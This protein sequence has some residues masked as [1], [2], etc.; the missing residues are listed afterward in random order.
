ME[1]KKLDV[2]RD[3]T[4]KALRVIH[5]NFGK[6]I[7]HEIVNGKVTR[8]DNDGPRP[9]AEEYSIIKKQA[10]GILRGSKKNKKVPVRRKKSRQFLADE[11][12]AYKTHAAIEDYKLRHKNVSRTEA[13]KEVLRLEEQTEIAAGLHKWR[14]HFLASGIKFLE[15]GWVALS[16]WA[17]GTKK[18]VKRWKGLMD[19]FSAIRSQEHTANFYTGANGEQKKIFTIKEVLEEAN[20][21]L[22]LWLKTSQVEKV[23]VE[24]K[25]FSTLKLLDGCRNE[26]KKQI[27]NQLEAI[28]GFRDN[29]GRIN[30]GANA[31]KTIATLGALYKRLEAAKIIPAKAILRK[32]MLE[33]EKERL[34]VLFIFC[35]NQ[36]NLF[37]KH[38]FFWKRFNE[39]ENVLDNKIKIIELL[40]R[41]FFSLLGRSNAAKKRLFVAQKH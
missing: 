32:K 29:L 40:K 19:I 17:E 1:E 21:L 31:A 6:S 7:I 8:V 13:M 27:L 33:W 37:S 39:T 26:Y 12:E 5:N 14:A 18:K 10:A 41:L 3:E 16:F 20:A 36:I 30:P 38:Q 11:K 2:I 25:L 24:K 34:D 15:N 4:G 22:T 35:A 9:P 23:N 28:I